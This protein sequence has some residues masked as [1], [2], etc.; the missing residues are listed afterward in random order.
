[1]WRIAVRDLQWR[2]RRFVIAVAAAA[3]VFG[4][5]LLIAGVSDS[6]HAEVGHI[7]RVVGANSWLVAAGTPGPFTTANAIPTTAADEARRL[8]GVKAADPVVLLHTTTRRP[9]G[10][11]DVNVLGHIPGGLG[12][13]PITAGRAERTSGEVVADTR[14]KV[15]VGDDLRLSHDTFRVVGLAHGVSYYFGTPTLFVPL[16]D[17]QRIAFFGQPLAMGIAMRGI[18]RSAP[19]GLQVISDAAARADLARTLKNGSQTI[20]VVN[21][22]LWIVAAGIIASIVYLSALERVRDFAVLKAT[23]A[24]SGSLYAGLALQAFALSAAAAVL[25]VLVARLLKPTFPFPIEL[26]AT[27]LMQLAAVA[28]VISLLASLA[29]LRRA[30][31]VDPALA[32]GGP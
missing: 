31:R 17:A 26:K 1:M 7:N 10:L 5:T 20:D 28:I 30:V 9:S 23:G 21:A 12:S 16:V 18:P 6:L 2:R 24:S 22:L 15:K 29:G 19:S 32:F 4:L 8:P 27:G 13:P 14:L 11:K 25:G 3:L